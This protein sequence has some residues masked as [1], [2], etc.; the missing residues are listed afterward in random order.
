MDI[1]TFKRVYKYMQ[2]IL[3]MMNSKIYVENLIVGMILVNRI[4]RAYPR[5]PVDGLNRCLQAIVFFDGCATSMNA[6]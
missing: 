5:T 1:K 3:M 4:H 2:K 6:D